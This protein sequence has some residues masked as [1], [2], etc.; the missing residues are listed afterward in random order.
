[1]RVF[2]NN[3]NESKMGLIWNDL[4]F[5]QVW[6][7]VWESEAWVMHELQTEVTQC[8]RTSAFI[9][10]KSWAHYHLHRYDDGTGQEGSKFNFRWRWVEEEEKLRIKLEFRLPTLTQCRVILT[11]S[12]PP[13]PCHTSGTIMMRITMIWWI[14]VK[15]WW[16]ALG[17]GLH[18]QFLTEVKLKNYYCFI[19]FTHLT[20]I[21]LQKCL[22][23][24]NR[25]CCLAG[26]MMGLGKRAASRNNFISNGGHIGDV[27]A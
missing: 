16:W 14:F 18:T 3:L 9:S 12:V 1:M 7:W 19:L 23:I 13:R 24:N 20:I 4:L 8:K 5:A 15:A 27:T 6:W 17:R 26:M 11:Q 25:R 21:N 22:K 2:G 10:T